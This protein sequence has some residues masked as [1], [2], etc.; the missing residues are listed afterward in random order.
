MDR[1]EVTIHIDVNG[2]GPMR[3]NLRDSLVVA[4]LITTIKDKFNLDGNFELRLENSDQPLNAQSALN[5]SGV[6]DGFALIF[7]RVVEGTGTAQAIARGVHNPLSRKF[8][9]VYLQ[10]ERA[11]TQ[12]DIAW[13]PALIGRKDR[14]DP[15]NN[16]LLAVD[17]E[18]NEDSPTVSRHHACL[19]ENDGEFNIESLNAQNPAYLGDLRLS[20]NHK[21]PL[22]IG[23][24]IRVGRVMLTFYVIS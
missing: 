11:L 14:R 2:I 7:A 23:S 16:K 8:K 22:P 4:N 5:Q 12:Y 24:R 9:R 21:Y 1:M 17:L 19:T 3:A 18:D 10:E 15:S 13:Q 6:S 20:P